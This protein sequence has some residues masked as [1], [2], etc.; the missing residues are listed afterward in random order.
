MRTVKNFASEGT[1]LVATLHSPTPYTF[2]LFD[3]IFL[4]LRGRV[5]YFGSRDPAIPYFQ[6]ISTTPTA[7]SA[8]TDA[9]WLTDVI[10][11]ADAAGQAGS[12]ARFYDASVI[13][14]VKSLLLIRGSV[15][16]CA[17]R[18]YWILSTKISL[19]INNPTTFC[20][21]RLTTKEW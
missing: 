10:V 17:L 8:D 4:L 3:K 2:N 11:K 1:T 18:K 15:K 13:R 21:N 7:I 19:P 9:E 14:R 6:N 16:F 5:V 12:L 20:R